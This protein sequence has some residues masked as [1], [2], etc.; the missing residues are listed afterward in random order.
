MNRFVCCVVICL[1]MASC[2]LPKTMESNALIDEHS[3]DRE[4]L[5]PSEDECPGLFEA[6]QISGD[7]LRPVRSRNLLRG[8]MKLGAD[9]KLS[10]RAS[11]I[12]TGKG[13]SALAAVSPLE[14]LH[15]EENTA[16]YDKDM[17]PV[18]SL[19]KLH[20]VFLNRLTQVGDKTFGILA[21]LA[22]LKALTA[23]GMPNLFARV[24]GEQGGF[25]NLEELTLDA[26]DLRDKHVLCFSNV[27][28]LRKLFIPNNEQL[29]G[30]TLYALD[31][32]TIC[33]LDLSG[34]IRIAETSCAALTRL[35]QLQVLGLSGCK[36]LVHEAFG[37]VRK[38][39]GI[40]ALYVSDHDGLDDDC[41]KFISELKQ[42][43]YLDISGANPVSSKS[44]SSLGLLTGLVTLRA[45]RCAMIAADGLVDLAPLHNLE[46]LSLAG[47]EFLEDDAFKDAKA[48]WPKLRYLSVSGCPLITDKTFTYLACLNALESVDASGCE[49]VSDSSLEL[50]R[51][52]FRALLQLNVT[53][54]SKITAQ[55]MDRLRAARPLIGIISNR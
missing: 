38:C 53:N 49:G 18:V 1:A 48:H 9:E 20:A 55:A 16:L 26:C 25:P 11:G 33:E 36:Q 3:A 13:V 42:L 43:N 32:T 12:L 4:V 14:I 30:C 15:L 46:H 19:N 24:D 35:P 27:R 50:I 34:C 5:L 2:A 10:F 6:V 31:Q 39:T 29:C 44:T 37:Y 54:C 17:E 52:E 40:R 51:T 47:G 41:M 7:W 21:R 23:V 8:S 28:G 22:S 45:D